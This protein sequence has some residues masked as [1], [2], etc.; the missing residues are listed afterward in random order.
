MKWLK[1][2]LGIAA[3]VAV[4]AVLTLV[5]ILVPLVFVIVALYM[6]LRL[7]ALLLHLAFAPVVWLSRP[8]SDDALPVR[9]GYA[10]PELRVDRGAG[11]PLTPHRADRIYPARSL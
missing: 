3:L 9:K 4:L 10:R 7:A 1:L 6:V 2:K 11:G 8:M 5:L